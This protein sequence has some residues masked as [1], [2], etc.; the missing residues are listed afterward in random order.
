MLVFG[1]PDKLRFNVTDTIFGKDALDLSSVG[2][3]I[4]IEFKRTLTET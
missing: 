1:N 4:I 3:K 2:N